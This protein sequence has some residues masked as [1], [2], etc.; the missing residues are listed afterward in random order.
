MIE[1]LEKLQGGEHLIESQIGARCLDSLSKEHKCAIKELL[2]ALKN[3]AA[4]KS[5]CH[6]LQQKKHGELQKAGKIVRDS[7]Y[8]PSDQ[9]SESIE[10]KKRC[11]IIKYTVTSEDFVSVLLLMWPYG[12]CPGTNGHLMRRVAVQTLTGSSQVLCKIFFHPH[13]SQLHN[14][15]AHSSTR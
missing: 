13:I 15:N 10:D 9:K 7:C 6:L 2:E 14:L 5:V 8:T 4:H 1:C 3:T 11:C 12:T